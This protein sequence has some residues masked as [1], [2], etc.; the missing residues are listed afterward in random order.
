MAWEPKG[1]GLLP[2]KKNIL[3]GQVGKGA[4]PAELVVS[5]LVAAK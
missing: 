5:D 2:F 1:G 4:Y 3:Q